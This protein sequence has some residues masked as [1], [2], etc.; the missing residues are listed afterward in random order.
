MR[1]AVQTT[2]CREREKEV[3]WACGGEGAVS[4]PGIAFNAPVPFLGLLSP[5]LT[6]AFTWR[7]CPGTCL[8]W[9]HKIKIMF[10]FTVGV[11]ILYFSG[12]S[13]RGEAGL[14]DGDMIGKALQEIAGCLP[15]G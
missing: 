9:S 15:R 6:L 8:N 4:S 11:V 10:V 7:I 3:R 13:T 5:D 12:R 14:Q 2:L 1:P